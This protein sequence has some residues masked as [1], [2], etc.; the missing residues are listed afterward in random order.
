MSNIKSEQEE[1]KIDKKKRYIKKRYQK[2]YK[3]RVSG[4]TM[5]KMLKKAQVTLFIIIG[6]VILIAVALFLYLNKESAA[7]DLKE[8]SGDAEES[9]L[10]VPAAKTYLQG[11]L[12]NELE[13]AVF[14]M[15]Y[16]GGYIWIPDSAETESTYYSDVAYWFSDKRSRA[17][18][19]KEMETEISQYLENYSKAC[20]LKLGELLPGYDIT[21]KG[22]EVNTTITPESIDA[23]ARTQIRIAQ[24]KTVQRVTSI[25]LSLPIRL[26]MAVDTAN[27]AIRT[28]EEDPTSVD[29]TTLL[30][31]PQE[32]V[33]HDVDSLKKII[34]VR[35]RN[36]SVAGLPFQF[37]FAVELSPEQ[38]NAPA[39]EAPAEVTANVGERITIDV[40]ATDPNGDELV[41]SLVSF[42][43]DI[44]TQTGMITLTPES[45]GVIELLVTVEDPGGNSDFANIIVDVAG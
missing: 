35:D 19:L 37:M 3:K 7:T 28:L 21:F 44:D 32:I 33:V 4:A 34:V 8:E 43:H 16:Q 27:A 40:N 12:A 26:G 9:S 6:M 17:P 38:G 45:A 42:E 23:E 2:A 10:I 15:G 14:L 13:D 31:M 29:L 41:F 1:K 24:E 18:S 5:P 25:P 30:D 20:M 11:C 36:S 39:I 22:F